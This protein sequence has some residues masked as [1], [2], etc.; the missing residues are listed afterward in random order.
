MALSLR[1]VVIEYGSGDSGK[2]LALGGAPRAWLATRARES[3]TKRS[4]TS[5]S[6]RRAST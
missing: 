1:G 4:I 2:P 5:S 3:R 6:T